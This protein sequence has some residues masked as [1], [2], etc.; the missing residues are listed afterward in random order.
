[1]AEKALTVQQVAERYGVGVRSVVKWIRAGDL[2]AINC[3]RRQ[4]SVKPRWRICVQA[5]A[6][7]ET[8]RMSGP[9]PTR[10][11]RRKQTDFVPNYY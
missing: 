11:R 1:M 9:P 5:L 8:Q 7:F 4:G 10:T 2:R 3:G 6:E